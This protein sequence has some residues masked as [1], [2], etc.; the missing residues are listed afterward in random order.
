MRVNGALSDLGSSSTVSQQGCVLSPLL[1]I[2]YI[3]MC[4]RDRE[5]RTI[6]KYA[7][8]T[9]IIGL[10]QDDETSHGPVVNDFHD[11]CQKSFLQMPKL[12]A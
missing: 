4:H 8:D 1:F 3:N 9:V 7:D 6:L 10:L 2:L 11:W 12:K 5:D